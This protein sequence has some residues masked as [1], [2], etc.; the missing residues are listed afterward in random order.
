MSKDTKNQ[1]YLIVDGYNIIGVW[2]SHK[3]MKTTNRDDDRQRLIDYMA[4]YQGYSG[5]KL[6]LVFDAHSVEHTKKTE[7][8]NK[9]EIQYSAFEQTA[10]QYI[11]NLVGKLVAEGHQVFVATADLLEQ[12]IIFAKGALRMSAR[13]LWQRMQLERSDTQ[14]LHH[15][16]QT[17]K[18]NATTIDDRLN[19]DQRAKLEQWRREKN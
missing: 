1:T 11:E 9:L 15:D 16:H 10:D 4:D 14:N 6:I 18:R 2:T 17:A 7:W 3:Y 12:T 19:P 8:K 13:E 5:F